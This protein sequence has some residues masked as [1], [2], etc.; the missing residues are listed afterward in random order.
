[1][2]V[3][4]VLGVRKLVITGGTIGGAP[5]TQVSVSVVGRLSSSFLS[6][7]QLPGLLFPGEFYDRKDSSAKLLFGPSKTPPTVMFLAEGNKKE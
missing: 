7:Q 6:Y 5:S 3:P 1:V 2:G 4:Q